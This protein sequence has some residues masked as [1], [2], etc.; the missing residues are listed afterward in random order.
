[1]IRG[2]HLDI[3][4]SGGRCICSLAFAATTPLLGKSLFSE[5]GFNISHAEGMRA[6]LEV[7]S[8]LESADSM[9]DDGFRTLSACPME[10]CLLTVAFNI[11]SRSTET[12]NHEI[13]QAEY[14][15]YR[16]Q[17]EWEYETRM[18]YILELL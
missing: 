13:K 14:E 1:M 16:F 15:G 2:G 7:E 12:Q 4:E 18:K 5:R 3:D 6:E 17:E 11:L 8:S 10:I 9:T